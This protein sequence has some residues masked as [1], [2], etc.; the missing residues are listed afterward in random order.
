VTEKTSIPRPGTWPLP[1]FL[2]TPAGAAPERGWPAVVVVHEAYGPTEDMRRVVERFAGE[3]YVALLPDVFAAAGPRPLCIA[4]C[5]A[6][7]RTGSGP[8]MPA[9]AAAHQ[10]LAAR[11]DVDETRIGVIGF[12]MGGSFALAYAASGPDGVRVAAVNYGDVPEDRERL[13][14]ACPVV[15]SYGGRDR[16]FAPKARRLEDHLSALGIEHDVKVYDDAGHSFLTGSAR[17]DGPL[18]RLAAAFP[19]HAGFVEGAA[20]DAWRRI[21]TFFDHQLRDGGAATGAGGKA[22]GLG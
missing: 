13:A 10:C 1:G 19:L 8:A 6:G 20:S 14:K 12:C 16:M 9:I 22:G 18:A 7:A 3:G 5:L 17:P 2:A 4:R 11:P 21:F 15:A